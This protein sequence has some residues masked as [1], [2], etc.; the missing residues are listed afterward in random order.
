MSFVFISHASQDKPRIRRLV[1]ALLEAGIKVWL[2]NPPAAGYLEHEVLSFYRIR[3]GERGG[4]RDEINDAKREAACI[5]V[6]WSKRATGD[7][8]LEGKER[9]VWIN[10]ADFGQTMG[11]LVACTVDEVSPSSLPSTFAR[12]QIPCLDPDQPDDKWRAVMATVLDDIRR[13]MSSRNDLR[14]RAKVSRDTFAPFLADRLDQ[15]NIVHDAVA[16]ALSAGGVRPVLLSGPDNE[17]P[18]AFLSRLRRSSVDVLRDGGA[19]LELDAEWPVGAPASG[20]APMYL[21][22]LARALALPGRSDVQELARAIE[23]KARPVAIIHR[24]LAKQWGPDE[25]RRIEAW[26]KCWEDLAQSAPRMQAVPILQVKMPDA[27]PGWRRCPGGAS[28]GRVGNRGIWNAANSLARRRL[29][30]REAVALDVSPVLGP[31]DDGHA[32]SW[33]NRLCPDPGPERT[34][35]EQLIRETYRRGSPKRHGV[36]H[37]EFA[38]KM[39]PAFAAS[40][41]G[42]DKE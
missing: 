8:V 38:E 12:D 19:W 37:R 33:L 31:I 23:A 16:A 1:D 7:A 28:G 32:N 20:F 13:V 5:L 27:K 26:L 6:C 15:E 17:H 40:G 11:K 34:R 30:K 25:P 41:D 2:D 35:L 3:A 24:M 42:S 18:D 14:A 21:R 36:S 39:G 10:E 29:R 22:N 4:W 9:I